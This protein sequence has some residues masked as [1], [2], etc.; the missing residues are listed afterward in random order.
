MKRAD[1]IDIITSLTFKKNN[2]NIDRSKKQ[3]YSVTV[4]EGDVMRMTEI[5]IDKDDQDSKD[6]G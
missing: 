1:I 3:Q 6:D 4:I 5:M 2:H